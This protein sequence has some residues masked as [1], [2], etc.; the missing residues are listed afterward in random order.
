MSRRKIK[1]PMVTVSAAT[2]YT[3]TVRGD[4]TFRVLERLQCP[5]LYLY[6][7]PDAGSPCWAV[8]LRH[9]NDVAAMA[10]HLGG[11]A[12]IDGQQVLA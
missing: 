11:A 4:G 5:K 2:A 8:P 7:P 6:R 3:A 12:V 1:P 9:M 10:E